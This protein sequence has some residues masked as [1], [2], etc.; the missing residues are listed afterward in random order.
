MAVSCALR[1]VDR[2][3]AWGKVLSWILGTGGDTGKAGRV[4]IYISFITFG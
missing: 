4:M 2:N 1:R 3:R